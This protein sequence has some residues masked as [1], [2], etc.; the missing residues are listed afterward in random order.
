MVAFSFSPENIAQA[1]EHQAPPVSQRIDAMACL[2]RQGW[3]VGL[4][5][6]PLIYHEGFQENYAQ[7][8]D[9][10]FHRIDPKGLHSVSLGTFRVPERFYNKMWSLYPEEPLFSGPLK[11]HDGM[12]SYIPSIEQDLVSFSKDQLYLYIP[13]SMVFENQ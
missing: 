4:R 1:L 2:Q 5:F 9:S 11:P 12:V 6:D 13:K 8:L 3:P 10:I 7:L